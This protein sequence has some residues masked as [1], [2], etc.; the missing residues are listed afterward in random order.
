MSLRIVDHNL[1][2]REKEAD[3]ST[4]EWLAKY[5][6]LYKGMS[7]EDALNVEVGR[8]NRV[9]AVEY[10]TLLRGRHASPPT[11]SLNLSDYFEKDYAMY[12][13]GFG[14]IVMHKQYDDSDEFKCFVA[15]LA[16]EAGA[17]DA[18]VLIL[19]AQGYSVDEIAKRIRRSKRS[20]KIALGRGIVQVY[21]YV[22]LSGV[23][24]V[25]GLDGF[26]V[27]GVCVIPRAMTKKGR[28]RKR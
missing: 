14:E 15:G 27:M 10:I 13:L 6:P 5:D 4:C 11:L 23:K 24:S 25:S 26:D 9:T 12:P 16:V 19:S 1:G 20:A 7:Y 2:K 28:S 17:K 22:K 18:D 3:L 8:L 21:E